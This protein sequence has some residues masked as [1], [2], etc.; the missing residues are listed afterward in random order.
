M[1]FRLAKAA[2]WGLVFC[3]GALAV[4]GVLSLF[5]GE[6]ARAPIIV[7]F[8]GMVFCSLCISQVAAACAQHLDNRTPVARVLAYLCAGVCGLASVAG[9]FL[10]D[11]VLRGD[12]PEMPPV[13]M[14][15]VGAFVLS[16]VKQAM[17]FVIAA[18]EGKERDRAV[19]ADAV[20][21]AKDER[22]AQL[23]RELALA[24]KASQD[25]PVSQRPAKHRASGHAA[26]SF[27]RAVSEAEPTGA[28][29]RM[30]PMEQPLVER[31]F[32]DVSLKEIEDACLAI[33]GQVNE[34]GQPKTPSIRLVA[35]QCNVPKQR[36]EKCLIGHGVKLVT[37]VERLG[38]AAA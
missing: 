13:W 7:A 22:I 28:S 2:L 18:C 31:E 30:A 5:G 29:G 11:A 23:E 15:V 36:I 21:R 33:A 32:R 8:A 38:L 37:V 1:T 19:G 3:T 35:S 10:G 26:R 9:V 34:D 25:K 14:M 4:L 12:H 17:S 16:F 6:V 20:L 24:K 27:A